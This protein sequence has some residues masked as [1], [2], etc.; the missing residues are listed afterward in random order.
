MKFRRRTY[1]TDT[2]LQVKFTIIFVLISFIASVI[3]VAVFNFFAVKELEALAWSTHLDINSTG[4]IIKPLFSYVNIANFLFIAVL[5]LIT[6]MWM[7]KKT[8]GPL[9]RMSKDINRIADGDLSANISLRRKDE[10]QDTSD[11]LNRM[12]ESI[13]EGFEIINSKYEDVAE[14][15]GKLQKEASL[16][17]YCEEVLESIEGVKKAVKIFKV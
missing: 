16:T 6:G 4:E 17:K 15:V 7:M 12:T 14:K 10:F 2:K 8:T 11:E 9:Y 13:R 5:L 1:I 3:S